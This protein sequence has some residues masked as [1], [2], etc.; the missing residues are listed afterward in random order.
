MVFAVALAA[1]VVWRRR[2]LEPTKVAGGALVAVGAF[3]YSLGIVRR[4]SSSC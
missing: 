1:F 3:V 2:H 4:T